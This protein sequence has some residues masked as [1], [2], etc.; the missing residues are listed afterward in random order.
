MN[1]E[2]HE[3]KSEGQGGGEDFDALR[4]EALAKLGQLS[5]ITTATLLTLMLSNK[6]S[7]QSAIVGGPPPPP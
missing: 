3:S 6:A 7:A 4:R 5:G 1:E 2:R